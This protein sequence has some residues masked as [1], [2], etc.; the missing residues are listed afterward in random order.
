MI[1]VGSS[2]RVTKLIVA[3]PANLLKAQLIASLVAPYCEFVKVRPNFL[4]KN[5]C[6][7][8]K[9]LGRRPVM[10]DLKLHDIPSEVASDI[11]EMAHLVPEFVTVHA[12][13][14]PEMIT[15][16]R[17]AA[18]DSNDWTHRTKILAI[19]VLTS[20]DN[21]ALSMMGVYGSTETQVRRLARMA[22]DAG[23][24]GLVCSPWEVSVLREEHGPDVVLVCPGVTLGRLLQPDQRRGASAADTARAGADYVVV[25]RAIVGAEE[26]AEAARQFAEEI[27]GEPE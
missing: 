17:E 6:Q 21:N 10:L 25:G 14:G 1:I 5:G 27:K 22:L 18:N 16:A 11:R 7:A 15:A 8:V 4:L 13:G 9:S 24:D 20:L 23:A 3:L 26:P 2:L 12:A 19:T